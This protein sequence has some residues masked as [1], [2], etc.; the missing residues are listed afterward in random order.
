MCGFV[1]RATGTLAVA[2]LSS[3]STAEGTRNLRET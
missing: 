2:L 3:P 1:E